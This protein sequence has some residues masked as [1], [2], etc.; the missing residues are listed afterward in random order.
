MSNISKTQNVITTH[1]YITGLGLTIQISPMQNI[2]INTTYKSQ[3]FYKDNPQFNK[4]YH[5]N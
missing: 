5:K 3:K 4:K 1:K 2:T